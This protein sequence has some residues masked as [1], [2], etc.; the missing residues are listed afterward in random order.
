MSLEQLA[1]RLN[2]ISGGRF[3]VPTTPE[4]LEQA[5]RDA[6]KA[7]RESEL[8]Q[9]AVIQR[10]IKN[11]ALKVAL[12]GCSIPPRYQ[13]CTVD[14][15]QVY[16]S[17]QNIAVNFARQYASDFF[18]C[19]APSSF[20]FSGTTGTGKN[21]LAAA[22]CMQIINAGGLAKLATVNELDQQRHAACFGPNANMDQ[23]QFMENL[24]KVDLLV[25]DEVGLSTNSQS[26]KVFIDQ[27]INDR[28]N[29]ALP[30]GLISNM[31][32]D[33]LSEHLGPRIMDRLQDGG[34]NWIDFSWKSYRTMNRGNDQ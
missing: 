6:E 12:G 28:S 33:E 20:V 2:A 16:E 31:N 18:G 34:G 30:T 25:L 4:E 7:K 26:Q 13:D 32:M 14:N 24:A 17:A 10:N 9:A 23:V 27:L 5:R 11:H 3:R 1:S 21:H 8:E 22:I 15:Y 19:F 29:R